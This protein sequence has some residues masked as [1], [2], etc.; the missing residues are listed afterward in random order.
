MV[1]RSRL[2]EEI[3]RARA[4]RDTRVLD[5]ARK[6]LNLAEIGRLEGM[7]RE[8]V[9]QILEEAAQNGTPAPGG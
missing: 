4:E 9:R 7:S 6:G 2:K 5:Y 1:S 8:R 3:R